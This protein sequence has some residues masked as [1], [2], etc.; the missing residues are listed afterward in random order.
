MQEFAKSVIINDKSKDNIA[1]EVAKI[2][3][4]K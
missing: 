1:L 4:N 2:I 3:L